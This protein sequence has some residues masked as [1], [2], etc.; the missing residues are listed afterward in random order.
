MK[1]VANCARSVLLMLLAIW[2][3]GGPALADPLEWILVD[4]T[5]T[6]PSEAFQLA[7]GS[8]GTFAFGPGVRTA[9]EDATGNLEVPNVYPRPG[10][11]VEADEQSP[12]TETEIPLSANQ[13]GLHQTSAQSR[14]DDLVPC[15]DGSCLSPPGG[16][17]GDQP[18]IPIIDW[19]DWH[20]WT[21]AWTVHRLSR[22]PV[23]LFSLDDST[24]TQA[25]GAGVG[26]AHVLAALCGV[27]EAVEG[28][29]SVPQPPLVNMSFGRLPE[30]SEAD[31]GD[32]CD[33]EQLT[34]QLRRVLDH[35][36]RDQSLPVASAGNHGQTL[37]PASYESVLSVGS[38]DLAAFGKTG[39]AVPSWESPPEVDALLPSSGLCLKNSTEPAELWPAPAGSSYSSALLSGWLAPILLEGRI[40][41]PLERLWAPKWSEAAACYQLG[42]DDLQ[43]CNQEANLVLGRIMGKVPNTCWTQ[44][45]QEPSL[46][47]QDVGE[48]IVGIPPQLKSLDQW[49]LAGQAST[50]HHPAPQSQFCVPCVTS[51]GDYSIGSG[52]GEALSNIASPASNNSPVNHNS[53]VLDLSASAVGPGT[54]YS[55]YALLLRVDELLYPLL[56]RGREPLGQ[57]EHLA[58]G[59][60]ESLVLPLSLGLFREDRQ[61]SLVYAFCLEG[62]SI[63]QASLDECYWTSTP[64][65]LFVPTTPGSGT[66]LNLP[67]DG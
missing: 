60:Y 5:C 2:L 44:E 33:E 51:S 54:G 59:G 48:P 16:P 52:P 6:P 21:T 27:L 22:L 31:G 4:S 41:Y 15:A 39:E 25:L 32:I 38:L 34:C 46:I 23:H 65:L 36:E 1:I 35:L 28:P 17:N 19:G 43:A 10:V 37:F 66:P 42:D 3:V 61:S 47:V 30:A 20:G 18:W 11:L 56:A 49:I 58:T 9:C 55:L 53:L 40:T 24:V 64:I 12:T 14:E 45:L 13:G 62:G 67:D 7:C 29:N 57:L 63:E 8:F 50:G 26:D